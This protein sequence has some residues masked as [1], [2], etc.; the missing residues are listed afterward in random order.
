MAEQ[1]PKGLPQVFNS[2]P[3]TFQRRFKGRGHEVSHDQWFS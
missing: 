2:F 3:E 1:G